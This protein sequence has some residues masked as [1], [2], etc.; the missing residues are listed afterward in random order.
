MPKCMGTLASLQHCNVK[1][2]CN[3]LLKTELHIGQ[4]GLTAIWDYIEGLYAHQSSEPSCHAQHLPTKQ[5]LNSI[6]DNFNLD[7]GHDIKARQKS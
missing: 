2:L 4:Y 7:R 3:N 5:D 6:A 1:V